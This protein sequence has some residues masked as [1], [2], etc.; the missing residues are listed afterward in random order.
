MKK[1]ARIECVCQMCGK[2][3]LKTQARIDRG[4]N[5]FCCHKCSSDWV[6]KTRFGE[7]H[8]LWKRVDKECLVCGKK[9][10]V[11]KARHEAGVGNYCSK[12]CSGISKMGENSPSWKGGCTDVLLAIRGSRRSNYWRQ[13]IFVRDNF[14]CG[15]CHQIGGHLNAHHIK[16]F[17][18]IIEDI[19]N[20][21]PLLPLKEAAE[22]YE[23][24]WDINN[25][26]TYCDKCHRE[27]HWGKKC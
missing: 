21:L 17:S 16:S 8:Y 18:S 4:E 5:K 12:K 20:N 2:L 23:P 1:V 19:K 14:T 25:G 11:K 13:S 26:K 27:L 3:F 7:R 22:I 24:L 15:S 9:Y 10:K 6:S